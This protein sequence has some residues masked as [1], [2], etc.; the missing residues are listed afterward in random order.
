M[1]I[2]VTG[3]AIWLNSRRLRAANLLLQQRIAAATEQLQAQKDEIEQKNNSLE[4]VNREISNA[5]E[6]LNQAYEELNITLEMISS[7]KEE[8]QIQRDALQ[9]RHQQITDSIEAAQ[10]IQQAMLPFAE[11]MN[12]AFDAHFILYKPR[13]V[14]SGDFYWFTDLAIDIQNP[15]LAPYITDLEIDLDGDQRIRMQLLAVAD[16]TGHGV[17]GHL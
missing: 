16:C 3:L 11:R 2:S 17:P 5:N 13:D 10:L 15:Q 4:A 8:I 7:Q 14:V 12:N 6:A 9:H 1:G